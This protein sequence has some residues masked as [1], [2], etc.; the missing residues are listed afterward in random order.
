MTHGDA[1]VDTIQV[2]QRVDLIAEHAGD[3]E[4]AH[5]EEDDLYRDVLA[6]IAG[7]ST[8]PH[9]RALAA[10]ALETQAIS[11]ARHAA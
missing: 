7:S 3:Y 11:F 5:A 2:R 10:S 1:H 9:A 8:D 6:A 4:R